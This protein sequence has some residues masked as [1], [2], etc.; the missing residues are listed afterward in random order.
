MT[1]FLTSFPLT[2]LIVATLLLATACGAHA[3]L[4]RTRR[5]LTI[6]AMWNA[7]LV[8][9]VTLPVLVLIAPRLSV[10]CLPTAWI[11]SEST[12]VRAAVVP[13]TM[14]PLSQ[15]PAPAKPRP[16]ATTDVR[17][18]P[19]PDSGT[20]ILGLPWTWLM[21][22][23]TYGGGVL[24]LSVRL[25]LALRDVARLRK[26]GQRLIDVR[27]RVAA[28]RL[29]QRLGL[30]RRAGLRVTDDLPVP[31]TVGWWQPIVLIPSSVARNSTAGEREA[32]LLHE[33]AHIRRADYA[34]HVLHE[35][36]RVLYW[37]HPL[38]WLAGRW[39][40]AVREHVCDQVCVHHIGN[41]HGYRDTLLDVAGRIMG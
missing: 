28:D 29:S 2:L 14:A 40:V 10:P 9:L 21:V 32:I 37:P 8:A 20:T 23:S 22:T 6:S 41:A 25:W 3:V 36:V 11:A 26:S 12:S 13:P 16:P 39:I 7:V 17:R 5:I 19:Q 18:A 27:W 4:S 38:I 31:A 33:L 24:I 1:G 35:L 34:W 30:T 15:E